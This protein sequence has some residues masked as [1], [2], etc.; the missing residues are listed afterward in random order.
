M[1]VILSED[2][3]SGEDLRSVIEE[4]KDYQD[5]IRHGHIRQHVSKRAGSKSGP[6]LSRGASEMLSQA[7]EHHPLNLEELDH[8]ISELE[9]VYIKALQLKIILAAVPNGAIKRLLTSWIRQNLNDYSL[10]DFSYNQSLLGG[11][12]VMIGSRI[13]DF[14]LRR[15][16]LVAQPKLNEMIADV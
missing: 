1:K 7:M 11:M 5:F 9:A 2:I 12:V 15:E 4:L 3:I 13:F 10:I 16:L 14:S 6:D 8:L